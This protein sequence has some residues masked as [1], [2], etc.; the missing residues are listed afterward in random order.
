[1]FE[2]PKKAGD[3]AAVQTAGI[4]STLKAYESILRAD[5]DARWQELDRLVTARKAGK[6]RSLVEKEM[7]ACGRGEDDGAGPAPRDAI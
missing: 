2:N 3:W 6:L 1:M 7:A 4:E 5:P